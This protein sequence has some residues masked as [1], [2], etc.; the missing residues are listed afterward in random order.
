MEKSVAQRLGQ[1]GDLGMLAFTPV[2]I[3]VFVF[4]A[5]FLGD[6]LME[7]RRFAVPAFRA[8][9]DIAVHGVLALLVTLPLIGTQGS[10]RRTVA[11]FCLIFLTATL[12]DLDHFV[13]AGSLH[14]PP[15]MGLGMR[16]PTHSLTFAGVLGVVAFLVSRCPVV[17]WATFAALSSHVIRDASGSST[18]ILWPLSFVTIP[19]WAYYLGAVGLFLV[20]YLVAKTG[21][22]T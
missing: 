3:L 12:I 2:G 22:T 11:L 15:A 19:R 20:S 7:Q 21:W 4:L 10:L 14:L 1:L 17:G 5:D 16:P 6:L 18:P 9:F 8:L 13:A